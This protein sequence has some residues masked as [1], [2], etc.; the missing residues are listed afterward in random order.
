MIVISRTLLFYATCW[1]LLHD[2]VVVVKS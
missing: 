2:L 1:M